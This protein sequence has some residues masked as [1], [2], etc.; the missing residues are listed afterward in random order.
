MLTKIHKTIASSDLR[1]DLALHLKNA[2]KEPVIISK[3]RGRG[4]NVLLSTA[5]YNTLV[6][7]YEELTDSREL[8]S[9]VS[10]ETGKRVEWTQIKN[11]L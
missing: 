8:I 9:L 2:D 4:A 3:N 5:A 7:A 1:R 10:K 6:D 11:E